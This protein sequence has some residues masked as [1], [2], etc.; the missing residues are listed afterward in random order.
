MKTVPREFGEKKEGVS[1]APRPGAYGVIVENG[2][3]AVVEVAGKYFLPGG[4][5]DEGELPEAALRREL[6]EELGWNITDVKELGD[7]LDYCFSEKAN[8][9]IKKVETFFTATRTGEVGAA[10][11]KDHAVQ[12]LAP[13]DARPRMF[14]PG[15]AWAIARATGVE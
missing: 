10:E 5:V 6:H 4:G 7:A 9:Y 15:Q 11:E 2:K 13:G 14:H 12:W 8:A 3:V 1:Y